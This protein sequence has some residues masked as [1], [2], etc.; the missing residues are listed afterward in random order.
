MS[1]DKWEEERK[2]LL[3]RLQKAERVTAESQ[4][5]SAVYRDMLE[6]CYKA[7]DQALKNENLNLLY[8]I[9]G[10]LTFNWMP[11]ESEGKLWGK[12][13]LNAYM[14]DA[15]WLEHTKK[16]LEQIKAYA[17]RLQEDNETNAELKK[18]IIA[19]AEDG[20]ITHI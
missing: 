20:L 5:E 11:S 8:E 13:F 7:A 15:G 6:E 12:Y 1:E 10:K 18:R 16:A 19:T 3:E 14:R 2:N 4:A 9:T 17:E